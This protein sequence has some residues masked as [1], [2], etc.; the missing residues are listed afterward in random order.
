MIGHGGHPSWGQ[1]M[2][3]NENKDISGIRSLTKDLHRPQLYH[4][5]DG[6]NNP[7]YLDS[8]ARR[9]SSRRSNH[10]VAV[11]EPSERMRA[12][13]GQDPYII[14]YPSSYLAES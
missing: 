8:S 12:K 13:Y 6:R 7:N 3:K 9:Q 1:D 5:A 4:A 10:S 14:I 2:Y 11:E